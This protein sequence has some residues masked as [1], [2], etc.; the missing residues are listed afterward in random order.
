MWL[1]YI[2]IAALIFWRYFVVKEQIT[3]A[4]WVRDFYVHLK[5]ERE[6]KKEKERERWRER[7]S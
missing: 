2:S 7:E 5:K 3:F 1:L 6:S 4:S